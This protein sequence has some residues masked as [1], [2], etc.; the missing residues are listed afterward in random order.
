MRNMK[1]LYLI[2]AFALIYRSYYAFIR[3]PRTT[4]TGINT[5][6]AFGFCN[7]LLELLEIEQ[8]T[9]VAVV[10]APAAPTFRHEMFPAYKAHRPPMP[11]GLKQSIPGIRKLIDGLGIASVTVAGYE[12]DD[13]IGTL[14]RQASEEGYNVY[15]ITPDKDYM[16]LVNERVFMYKPGRF[17]ERAEI[18]GVAEVL[19]HFGIARV[20]QVVDILGL[21]GDAADNVPGCAGIGAKGATMLIEQYDS[22]EGV[23]QHVDELKGKQKE[24]LLACR[25]K[26]FLSREL[27]TICREVPVGIRVE[28]LARGTV[29]R[30]GLE[31]LFRELEFF[32]LFKRV[33]GMERKAGKSESSGAETLAYR[34]VITGAERQALLEHLVAAP[35]YAMCARFETGSVH[36][37]LPVALSFAISP[38]EGFHVRLPAGREEARKVIENLRPVLEEGGK[39]LLSDDVKGNLIWACRA[40]IEPRNKI[41]DVRVAHYVLQPDSSHDLERVATEMMNYRVTGGQA[42][43]SPQLSLLFEEDRVGEERQLVERAVVIFRLGKLL[44]EE[45]ERAGLHAL[46]EEIEMPLVFVLASMEM[47][48]VSIDE[49]ALKVFA[50]ELREKIEKEE[51]IIHEM[52]GREFN[53]NS[54]K[55]LGE[56]L[57]DEMNVDAGNKKTKTG[58][59]STSEQVL[60]RLSRAHPVIDHILDYRGSRKLLTTYAEALPAYVNPATGKIHT[61]F[62]QSEASTGRLSSLNPNL[63]NIPV[64][65]EE[66]RNIRKA[67]VT[68]DPDYCFFSVDYS[69]VEL[70]LMAHLSQDPELIDAFLNKEDVHA[71]TASKIYR[72]PLQEV[73]PEM[74]RR[75]KMANF[76]IIYGISAWGLAERLRVSRK[77]GKELIDGYFQLYPGVKTYMERSIEKAREQ[78]YVETIMGRRRY[79]AD[80]NSRNAVVRGVAERNAINAPIQ[81]SAADIIKKAMIRV[82]QQVKERGMRSRMILQVHDEL[83][84]TCHRDELQELRQLVTGCMEHV[85]ELSVPLSVSAGHGENWYEAH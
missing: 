62:N 38:R 63:Q 44:L 78:G 34:E 35:A 57:F 12:A 66:G 6:A 7:F 32:S 81:G 76:G 43:N 79:L 84:F 85:V 56:I 30:E 46:F 47:E 25:E 68:G 23:Y 13:V 33:P 18:W 26:V 65:T 28:D 70:R 75:A 83:N 39:T 27:V 8:P 80:I 72:V 73:T 60:S 37:S 21:M 24:S 2:D 54:P 45:L 15:M 50:G 29:D 4:T 3:A 58:Q 61:C 67:F 55:Q 41:F 59:Y 74:R 64:R 10:F 71:A 52:A 11:E 77:E 82:H 51:K 20:E 53:I 5:S 42:T 48:G 40:G 22:I 9:H 36:D 19:A 16:Q 31:S 14:A 17:R 1:N 49:R 69:Q